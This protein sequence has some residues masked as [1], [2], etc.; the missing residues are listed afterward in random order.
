MVSATA[1]T[2]SGARV[3]RAFAYPRSE[4]RG[5]AY[6][7]IAMVEALRGREPEE[8]MRELADQALDGL[9]PTLR[10]GDT[11]ETLVTVLS[12]SPAAS[13]A[14][15]WDTQAW[16]KAVISRH[17]MLKNAE[18]RFVTTETGSV[19]ALQATCE[20]LARGPWSMALFG[21]VDSLVDV[22]TCTELAVR[23]RL[24]TTET[25]EGVIPGEAGAFLLLQTEARVRQQA[26]P[27]SAWIDGMAHSNKKSG[28][29]PGHVEAIRAALA[30]ANS[31]P[32]SIDTVVAPWTTDSL[33]LTE[34]YEVRRTLWPHKVPE[35]QSRALQ[36]GE[37][38]MLEAPDD[39][40]PSVNHLALAFG[41]TGA[42]SLALA[43][44]YGCGTVLFDDRLAAA[45][46][47]RRNRLLVA[48]VEEGEGRSAVIL[49][50]P[51]TAAPGVGQGRA[52]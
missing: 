49:R 7:R 44:G 2:L 45:G 25:A 13:R 31:A 14:Q 32:E 8:R 4:G 21:A 30:T 42:A 9:A 28:A 20:E 41:D 50:A 37:L 36:L 38:D 33:A 16:K 22:M 39:P 27:V 40:A 51:Y 11:S 47:A 15:F 23:G 48:Q 34:W 3:Q 26:A 35:Q 18:F 19:A 43:L 5:S 1:T 12:P 52:A 17:E 46:L 29:M 24:M 6:A 10:G